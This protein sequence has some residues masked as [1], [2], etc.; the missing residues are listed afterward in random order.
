MNC[1]GTT[2]NLFQVILWNEHNLE[3]ASFRDYHKPKDSNSNR[4]EPKMT[5]IEEPN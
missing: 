2:L 5:K 4:C 1:G 3:Y